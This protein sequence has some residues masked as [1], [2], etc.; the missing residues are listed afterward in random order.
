M[1]STVIIAPC[2]CHLHRQVQIVH[3]DGRIEWECDSCF[4]REPM[5]TVQGRIAA[6]VMDRVQQRRESLWRRFITWFF[7]PLI[8]EDELDQA[9]RAEDERKTKRAVAFFA[10]ALVT[11][12]TLF[13]VWSAVCP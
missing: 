2:E 4:R 10:A 1:T 5:G 3:T 7:T 11:I 8:N 9:I 6:R 13:L 12:A